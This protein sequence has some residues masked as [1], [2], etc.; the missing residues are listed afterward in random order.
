LYSQLRSNSPGEIRD[1]APDEVVFIQ[2]T[3]GSTGTPKCIQETHAGIISHIHG[4]AQFLGYTSDDVSLNWLP[5]DHVV[6]IL[7]FHCKDV[8]LACNQVQVP[9]A[10]VL[11]EPLVWLD[12]MEKYRVSRTWAPNFGFKLVAQRLEAGPDRTWDLLCIKTFMNAG[13]QVTPS[14][15]Q[16][17]IA[18][19]VSSGVRA[20]AMQPA[21][22]MAEV[23]T[24][25]TY[26][27]DFDAE[28]SIRRFRQDSTAGNLIPAS[29]D[30]ESVSFV[31]LGPPIPGVS[32]RITDKTNRPLPEGVIGRLQIKGNVVTPGYLDNPE[33]NREAFVGDGWF[34][35]GDL[36]FILDGRL[37]VTGR[38]KEMINIRGSNLFCYEVEDVVQRVEGVEPTYAAAVEVSDDEAG[39]GRLAILFVPARAYEG[40]ELQAILK[41]IRKAVSASIGIN[42]SYVVPLTRE[43]F[44]KTSSG[45]IQRVQMR[46]ALESGGYGESFTPGFM[47]LYG[48]RLRHEAVSRRLEGACLFSVVMMN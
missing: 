34:N 11:A 6:P 23:C 44:P 38:E 43:R 48:L 35:S 15:V 16:E 5:V 41:A 32:I 21:F 26:N 46:K 19:L 39:T 1:A 24:C 42:P 25:M 14:V 31:D 20:S 29:G 22:G 18:R 36:G 47:S 8:Y 3:S 4:S 2:L 10:T 37:T 7:T 30:E 45:K 13:E 27:D 28:R 33:A 9:T 17:F 40:T 12:L